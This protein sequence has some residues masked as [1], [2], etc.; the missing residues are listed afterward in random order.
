[1]CKTRKT[2]TSRRNMK[3]YGQI[4]MVAMGFLSFGLRCQI[5]LLTKALEMNTVPRCCLFSDTKS[6]TVRRRR[7]RVPES[8]C[9]FTLTLIS[10]SHLEFHAPKIWSSG[11]SA[12]KLQA[13][14]CSDSE[15]LIPHSV[16]AGI[17]K[18]FRFEHS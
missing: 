6:P 3:K 8:Q 2:P 9:K 13:A 10:A 18:R 14:K 7:R 5:L 11:F 15:R 16:F 1:M 4:S 12:Q 17:C